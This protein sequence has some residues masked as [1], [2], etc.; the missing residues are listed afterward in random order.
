MSLPD[1]HRPVDATVG[2]ISLRRGDVVN[3][4]PIRPE[5]EAKMVRFHQALSESSASSRYFG[6]LKLE[7]RTT[8]ER[9]ARICFLDC[10]RQ[11]ALVAESTPLRTGSS[12]IVAMA[13]PMRPPGTRDAE[14]A[15]L[16]SDAVQGQGLGRALLKRLFDVGR[17]WG[18]EHIV[19]E[20]LPDNERMR[21][22]CASLGF[23]FRGKN[24]A[25]RDLR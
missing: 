10:D 21:K 8:H 5:D 14:F 15:L 9:L 4:R 22:V 20:I 2:T 1:Q 16:V 23:I 11:I 6:P 7:T 17:D 18:V 12:E 3:I 13:R 24:G 19:S 25:S